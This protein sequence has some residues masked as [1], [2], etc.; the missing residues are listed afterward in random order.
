MN[1]ISLQIQTCTKKKPLHAINCLQSTLSHYRALC[2]HRA[3]RIKRLDNAIRVLDII[4]SKTRVDTSSQ[5]HLRLLQDFLQTDSNH[6]TQGFASS[7]D[8]ITVRLPNVFDEILESSVFSEENSVSKDLDLHEERLR[9]DAS[10]L[11]NAVSSYGSTRDIR[12]GIQYHCLAIRCGFVANVYVGSSLI[13][14][15]SKCYQTNSAYKLFEEMPIRNVVSWTAIIAAFAQEWEVEMCLELYRKMRDSTL[16]PNEYTFTSILSAC[17]GSGAFGQGRSVH[18]QTIQMGFDSYVHVANALISMYCKCGSVDESFYVFNNMPSKDIVSWNSMIAGYGQHGLALQAM[19][20]FEEM[21]K[22]REKP[23]AL[24]YLGVLSSCRHAGLVKEG[25]LYFNSMVE[26]GF[27]PELDHYSCMVDLL[28]RA[29]LLEE[30]RDFIEKMPI[31][32]NAVIWGS[33]LSSCRLH[34]DVWIGIQAAESRLFLEPEC[35]ATHVQLANLYASVKCWDQA[36]RVRKLMK[37]KGL[38]TNT[39]YSWIDIKNQVYRFRAED[40]SNTRLSEILAVLDCLVDHMKT[41]GF[42]PEMQV[43]HF[44]DALNESL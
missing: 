22:Q 21:K 9:V 5:V 19:D 39:G 24:T 38:K 16:N 44:D 1:I 32:P 18:C 26:H 12:R 35:A 28:G 13:S 11:S 25:K 4:T 34:R 14:F 2:S 10:V 31:Q 27:K 43:E 37:D 42:P 20:L 40:K 23:D 29:G 36:A 15:Y 8:S 7:S 3:K 6:F 33:L 30:A 17:T 41:S